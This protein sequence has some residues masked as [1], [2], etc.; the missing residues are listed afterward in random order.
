MARI[1]SV[2]LSLALLV[3]VV[4]FA[5]ANARDPLVRAEPL[6]RVIAG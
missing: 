2:A 6:A 5:S 1:L 4:G 3:A